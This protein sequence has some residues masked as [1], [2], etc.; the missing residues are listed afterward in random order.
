[1][2]L[3]ALLKDPGIKKEIYYH[4][5]RVLKYREIKQENPETPSISEY[6]YYLE[7]IAERNYD[8]AVS[9]RLRRNPAHGKE[10]RWCGKCN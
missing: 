5:I 10:Q 6:D 8:Q 1:M 3:A 9:G 7:Q 4:H 2:F